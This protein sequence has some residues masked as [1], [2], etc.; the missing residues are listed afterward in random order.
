MTW[1]CETRRVVFACIACVTFLL[2]GQ[3]GHAQGPAGGDG[4]R[5]RFVLGPNDQ[6]LVRALDIDG[7]SDTPIRIDPNG[8]IG[9][10]MIGRIHAAG[11]SIEELEQAVSDGLKV[12]V[13]EPQVSV[14]VVEYHSQPVSVMGA[15]R[16]PGVQQLA[17]RKTLME[18]LSA[19]GGL[20]PDAGHVVTITRRPE[21]GA[22]PASQVRTN[23]EGANVATI[24][25]A[26]LL[27][28]QNP[29][30]N[31]LVAPHDVITVPRGKLV[32]VIGDVRKAGAFLLRDGES[33]SVLKVLSLAEGALITASLQRATHPAPAC[34]GLSL[35]GDSG[36]PQ[37]HHGR[38][39]T[40]RRALS[41]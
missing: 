33:I 16:S 23:G 40:G 5:P 10:P 41:G 7:I 2:A 11:L 17:G 36:A 29:A 38:R 35:G 6:I 1:P 15:V 32:Y 22:I 9:L 21:W 20:E 31:I 25:L 24:N 39:G 4:A 26:S 37:E 3:R 34:R 27:E 19:A 8:F 14:S 28:A 18:V 30:E 12:F 13:R